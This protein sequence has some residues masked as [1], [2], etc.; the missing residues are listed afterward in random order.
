[1]LAG[2]DVSRVVAADARA[3]RTSA[4]PSRAV[5]TR[6]PRRKYLSYK[7]VQLLER[8]DRLTRYLW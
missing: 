5:M 8:V 3:K 7:I 2:V 6:R 4:R 1:L